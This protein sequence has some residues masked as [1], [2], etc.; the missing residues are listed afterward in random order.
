MMFLSITRASYFL[1]LSV[2][3]GFNR[4]S[5]KINPLFCIKDFR[6]SYV[7]AVSVILLA[8]TFKTFK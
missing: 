6:M 8:E 2:Y 5:S 1:S 4:I 7:I 3:P